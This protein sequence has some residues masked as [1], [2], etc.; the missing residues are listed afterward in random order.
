MERRNKVMPV[1]ELAQFNH[2]FDVVQSQK[3]L[4]TVIVEKIVLKFIR[5]TDD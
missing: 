3:L 5:L 1:G 4:G 2:H